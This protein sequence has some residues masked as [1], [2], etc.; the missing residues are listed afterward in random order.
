MLEYFGALEK[1]CEVCNVTGDKISTFH[2]FLYETFPTGK[3]KSDNIR[4]TFFS[5]QNI[6]ECFVRKNRFKD[7][8]L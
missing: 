3:N 6:K 7:N 4:K 1:A 2:K 8:V 5:V